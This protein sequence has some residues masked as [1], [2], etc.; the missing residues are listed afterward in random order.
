[1]NVTAQMVKELRERTGAGFKEC[2]DILTETNGDMQL[3]IERLREKGIEDAGKKVGREAKEG[4]IEI[5]VHPGERLAAMVEINCETDF[6]ARTDDFIKLSR[7]LA[8]HIAATNPTYLHVEDVPG[9]VIEASEM[10]AQKFYEQQV[11]MAQPFI[12]DET[13]TIEDKIKQHIAKLGENIVVNRFAR[14]EVG[15]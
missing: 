14:Y 15:E 13:T 2:R 8:L 11:L 5:Y 9:A 7:E 1:V 12:K 10:S 4:R 3:A 6:V